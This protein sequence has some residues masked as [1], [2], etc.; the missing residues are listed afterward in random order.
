MS[1]I[2]DD[3]ESKSWF[4]RLG[5]LLLR[6]PQDREQLI[7]LLRDAQNRSL[8]DANTLSMIEGVISFA[9]MKVRNIMIP[10]CQMVSIPQT[11]NLREI[12]E[13]VIE[14]GH[15]RFPITADSKDE[16]IGI[17]HAKDL[18][19]FR[20][21]EEVK[22]NLSDLIRQASFVPESKRLDILLTEFRKNRN[23][24]AIVVDEY[25]GVSGFVTIEDIIEQIIG[26]IED[27]FDIDEDA[28]IKKHDDGCYIIKAHMP[29]DDFNEQLATRFVH[30]NYDTIGGILVNAFGHLPQC[31]E[32]VTI[33]ELEFKIINADNRRIKLI[34]CF[35][36]RKIKA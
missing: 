2:Q 25:G 16:V 24:M 34:E 33:D 31:G 26:D 36:N 11:A 6:E 17:L 9:E 13:V 28:F 35:D 10:R 19:R 32:V 1:E 20:L 14:S 15:S 8:L 23:H 5:Q 21:D 18:L 30:P 3:N 22:F 27:E 12:F 4:E 29:L 7:T